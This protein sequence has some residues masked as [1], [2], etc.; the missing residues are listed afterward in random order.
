MRALALSL[1]F[2]FAAATLV[3]CAGPS[4]GPD[5]KPQSNGG[6]GAAGSGGGGA[7]GSGGGGSTGTG[8]NGGD[9]DM[10]TTP[11]PG[12]DGGIT[13][14]GVGCAAYVQCLE[15]AMSD[16]DAMAC[17]TKASSNAMTI[18]DAVDTCVGNYCLG[19]AG[20]AARCKLNA[21]DGSMQNLDGTAAFDATTGAPTGDCG[22]CLLNGDAGLWGEACMP[23]TDAACNTSA[24]TQQTAACQADK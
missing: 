13:T 15:A 4:T 2:A 17:D 16:A 6:G 5:G 11:A 18:L 3:A 10:G 22:V 21:T 19:M 9:A 7:A 24:C 8:G 23:T 12:S 20:A 14:A 1:G